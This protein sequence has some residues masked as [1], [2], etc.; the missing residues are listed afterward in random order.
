MQRIISFTAS[1]VA[2]LLLGFTCVL[3]FLLLLG[4]ANYKLSFIA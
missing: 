2:F 3:S 1:I 4:L